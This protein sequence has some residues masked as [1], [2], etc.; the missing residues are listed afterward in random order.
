MGLSTQTLSRKKG[1]SLQEGVVGLTKG[2]GMEKK[3]LRMLELE[4]I[5]AIILFPLYK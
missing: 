2:R 3:I 5:L 4:M 1:S